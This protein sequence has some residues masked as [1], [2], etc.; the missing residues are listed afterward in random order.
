MSEEIV[1]FPAPDGPT[2][3]TTVPGDDGEADP[4]QHLGAAGAL[5]DRDRLERGDRHLLGRR[6]AE[7]DVAE[8]DGRRACRDGPGV[9]GLGDH[10]HDVE[11]L[12][13][14]LEADDGAREVDVEVGQLH[15]RRE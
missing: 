4:V 5:E 9:G 1:D 10:R 11:H 7:P 13:H 8:L 15:Q 14:P 6:V 3:A 12:E 2:R